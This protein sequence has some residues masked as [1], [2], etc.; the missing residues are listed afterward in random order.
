MSDGVLLP[1]LSELLC[2]LSVISELADELELFETE[3]LEVLDDELCFSDELDFEE[4]LEDLD[5]ELD[6]LTELD[7]LCCFED[8][9]KLLEF[10]D[11][12]EEVALEL[13]ELLERSE[14]LDDIEDPEVILF[15]RLVGLYEE[16]NGFISSFGVSISSL[17]RFSRTFTAGTSSTSSD[18][19]KSCVPTP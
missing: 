1:E 2:E 17:V 10:F 14:E 11:E 19:R 18:V 6:D 13:L 3:L 8:E 16:L 15:T 12:L 7:E 4:E 9:V 5:D